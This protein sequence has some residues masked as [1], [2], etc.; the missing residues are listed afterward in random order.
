MLPFM[1]RLFLVNILVHPM[2]GEDFQ[3]GSLQG[4]LFSSVEFAQGRFRFTSQTSVQIGVVSG[5]SLLSTVHK[6]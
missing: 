5:L 6:I 1:H 4:L 2:C 3:H